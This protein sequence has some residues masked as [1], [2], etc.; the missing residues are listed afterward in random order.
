MIGIGIGKEV[1]TEEA[2]Y[3]IKQEVNLKRYET[4][5]KIHKNLNH[6]SKENMMYAYKNANKLGDKVRKN[7]ERACDECNVCKRF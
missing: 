7:I 5:K 2:V 1:S 4:I 6:K 3:Y